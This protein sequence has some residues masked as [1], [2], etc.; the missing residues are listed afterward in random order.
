MKELNGIIKRMETV[1]NGDPWYGKAVIKL[2]NEVNPEIVYKKDKPEHHSII[3]L[4]FHM[5]NWQEFTLHQ[6]EF[7]KEIDPERY[8]LLDWRETNPEL[9]TW[10]TGIAEFTAAHNKILHFLRT[11]PEELLNRKVRFRDYDMRFL[12]N[13]LIEHNIYHSGQ[14][15]LINKTIN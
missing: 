11:S 5:L 4:L 12:L 1:F 3:E 15:A 2:L 6:L 14:I 10:N 9:H 7:E 8:R 13:G